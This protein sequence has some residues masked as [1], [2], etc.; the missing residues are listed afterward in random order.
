MHSCRIDPG[1]DSDHLVA[2]RIELPGEAVT[3]VADKGFSSKEF[4]RL[5]E[6]YGYGHCI[7][8]KSNKKAKEPF[9]KAHYRKRHLIENV[10]AKMGRW[11]RLEL[12]RE[13]LPKN[14]ESF[15][16]LWAI[17]TWVKF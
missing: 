15:L 3:I 16:M 14:F 2:K 9:N 10:F 7:A 12:R 4:R 6:D 13:R 17:G 11:T 8:Q 1:N 5:L